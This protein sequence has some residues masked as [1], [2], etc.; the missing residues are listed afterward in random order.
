MELT[1]SWNSAGTS[2]CFQRSLSRRRLQREKEKDHPQETKTHSDGK[3]KN[4]NPRIL[5][6]VWFFAPR[7]SGGR[8][9][10]PGSAAPPSGRR[11]VGRTAP[12]CPWRIL[13][14][15]ETDT[16]T[17]PSSYAPESRPEKEGGAIP[18]DKC[19]NKPDEQMPW[20][21]SKKL[22]VSMLAFD[23]S[24]LSFDVKILPLNL[25][26]CLWSLSSVLWSFN[27]AIQIQN[28][29]LILILSFDL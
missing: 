6:S 7:G 29:P 11:C 26:M 19:T 20:N 28:L 12:R 22:Q 1:R 25:K 15:P 16:R 3:I 5:T 24:I 21:Y 2:A 18:G 8:S 14:R 4:S 9:G 13:P 27:F 23:V 10:W 17:L